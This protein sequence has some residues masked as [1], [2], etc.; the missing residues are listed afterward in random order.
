[1]GLSVTVYDPSLSTTIVQ[2][3]TSNGTGV[4]DTAV[5]FDATVSGSYLVKIVPNGHDASGS[6]DLRLVDLGTTHFIYLPF[7]H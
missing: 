1:M 4:V 2:Q 7:L 6:Y 5:S 3:C